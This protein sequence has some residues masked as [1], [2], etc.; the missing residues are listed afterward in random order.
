MKKKVFAAVLPAV[1]TS[2]DTS[3][4]DAP[5]SA[6]FANINAKHLAEMWMEALDRRGSNPRAAITSAR[7]LLES[8]C[9]HVLELA[10][11]AYSHSWDLNQLY[12]ATAK[13]LQ[14]S[15]TAGTHDGFRRLFGACTSIVEGIGSLRNDL[16]D[17]H[18][19]GRD[20]A[21]V[22]SRHAE[23]A[24]NL[25]GA[26][27]MYLFKTWTDRQ[28]TVGEIFQAYIDSMPPERKKLS[29][30]PT[31]AT[32]RQFIAMAI[33]NVIAPTMTLDDI[34][35]HAYRRQS[36]GK[37]RSTILQ[38]LSV[39]AQAFEMASDRWGLQAPMTAVR[40]ARVLLKQRGVAAPS[41]PV[42]RILTRAEYDVLMDYF[43]RRERERY[44]KIKMTLLIELILETACSGGEICRML[45]SDLIASKRLCQV[46]RRTV[47]LNDKAW[48][49]IQSQPENGPKIFDYNPDS[50]KASFHAGTRK[51]GYKD[52]DFKDL[53]FTAVI[54]MFERGLEWHRVAK[55]TG[56][57]DYQRL[58][59]LQEKYGK[60]LASAGGAVT[61]A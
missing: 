44:H 46:G 52:L 60:R 49:I 23:L 40:D 21:K 48:D 51:L 31:R 15:P 28:Y 25:A 30:D 39:M 14:L 45:R 20:R 3:P 36:D 42:E 34:V 54:R 38:D 8:T 58:Q 7:S 22:E 11:V 37:S 35:A 55:I 43:G 27:A 50:A 17:A 57:K 6:F 29:T 61:V 59:D 32:L 4:S 33:G 19:P 47:E 16:S 2:P 18:G 41:V 56:R 12:R 53:S 5:V 24:V 9:K 1:P 13:E 26:M 10:H